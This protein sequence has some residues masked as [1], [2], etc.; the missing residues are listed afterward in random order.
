MDK[1]KCQLEAA[2]AREL[3]AAGTVTAYREPLLG[4]AQASD[5]RMLELKKVV[6]PDHLLPEEVLAGARTVVA[7]FLPFAPALVRE[8]VGPGEVAKSW[9]WA[10]VETNHLLQCVALAMTR[11]LEENG[12]RAFARLP[13]DDFDRERLVSRWSHR[14][15]AIMA[16]LG[17][18]GRNRMLITPAG[19]AGRLTTLV[20]CA[21][22]EPT[23]PPAGSFCSRC[24]ECVRSCPVG[25]LG[26][27]GEF[28]RRRCYAHLLAVSASN[29]DMGKAE[30]C[31]K[32][33]TG[34]CSVL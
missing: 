25:A 16:G 7:V 34:P 20:T 32:C 31:G 2:V 27:S 29:R 10:Y 15:L 19:S 12:Y 28:D 26:E 14:H 3:S 11:V 4:Y 9:L 17:Q 8:N 18:L 1:L 30:A 22:L 21:R 24:G 6:S 5:P 13:T 23:A 33:V